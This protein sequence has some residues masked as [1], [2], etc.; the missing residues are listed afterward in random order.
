LVLSALAAVGACG[1]QE[2]PKTTTVTST[3]SASGTGG[4]LPEPELH[5]AMAETCTGTPPMGNPIPDPSGE[6]MQ[7]ADCVAGDNGR[8]VW[9][10]GGSNVCMYD[11][12]FSDADCGGVAVCACRIDESFGFNRCFQGNCRVDADCPGGYCSPSG[13]HIYSSCMT[14]ISA[15]SIGFFCHT[16]ED[17]CIDDADCGMPDAAACLFDVSSTRWA[18]QELLCT[19]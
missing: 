14:G 7:D 3:T 8:C 2:E 15:G 12:C 4:M 10:F 1:T 5:R 18:C 13:V 19:G 16:P 9:P 11:E 17:E 6:C